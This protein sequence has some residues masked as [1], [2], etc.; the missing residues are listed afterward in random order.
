MAYAS[1]L[2]IDKS[3]LSE[4]PEKNPHLF[5]L[6]SCCYTPSSKIFLLSVSFPLYVKNQV[7]R[8]RAALVSSGLI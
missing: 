3:L 7:T 6:A 2:G 5:I 1:I 4:V 8:L